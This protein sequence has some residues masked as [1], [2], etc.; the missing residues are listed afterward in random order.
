MTAPT[1]HLVPRN[2]GKVRTAYCGAICAV[3]SD[4]VREVTGHEYCSSNRK[5]VDCVKCLI[6]AREANQ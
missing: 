3:E 1:T 5:H 4:E 2:A 6:E